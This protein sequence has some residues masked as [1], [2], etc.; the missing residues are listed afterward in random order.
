[1]SGGDAMQ[2]LAV[3]AKGAAERTATEPDGV[4]N[5]RVEDRLNI[6]LRLSDYAEDFAGRPLSLQRLLALRTFLLQG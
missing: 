4:A 1:M 2:L 5:D 6:G 3:I